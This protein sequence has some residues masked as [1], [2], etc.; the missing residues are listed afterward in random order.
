MLAP[1]L[2]AHT[3]AS[4]VVAMRRATRRTHATAKVRATGTTACTSCGATVVTPR[5]NAPLSVPQ[6]AAAMARGY[7]TINR[8]GGKGRAK[9]EGKEVLSLVVFTTP[10]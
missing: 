10:L 9:G 3:G 1:W 4:A 7:T 5:R 6:T 2:T 8:R